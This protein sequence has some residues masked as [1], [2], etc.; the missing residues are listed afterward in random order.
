M[1]KVSNFR[2]LS[3]HLDEDLAWNT[4]ATALLQKACYICY[5]QDLSHLQIFSRCVYE[6]FRPALI[7]VLLSHQAQ[8]HSSEM[9]PVLLQTHLCVKRRKFS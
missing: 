7:E 5:G 4:N 3:G 1:E 6:A 9:F 2:F 8:L